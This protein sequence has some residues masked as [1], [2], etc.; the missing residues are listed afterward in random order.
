MACFMGEVFYTS[1]YSGGLFGVKY[2][3]FETA[4][5]KL[6]PMK[7]SRDTQNNIVG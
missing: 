6:I 7:C 1:S 5:I 4:E 3:T 2:V